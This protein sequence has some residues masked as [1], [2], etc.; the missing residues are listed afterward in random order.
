M[1]YSQRIFISETLQI[2]SADFTDSYSLN[3]SSSI[4]SCSLVFCISFFK[5]HFSLQKSVRLGSY[6][7]FCIYQRNNCILH[8]YM[9]IEKEAAS[10][11]GRPPLQGH[12]RMI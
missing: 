8:A 7:A 5:A 1:L 2:M 3:F 11:M 10:P 4:S 6:L 12:F 9:Q